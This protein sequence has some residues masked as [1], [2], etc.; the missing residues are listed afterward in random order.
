MSEQNR[1]R[2]FASAARIFHLWPLI[3]KT[4]IYS[5]YRRK[6]HP[7]TLLYLDVVITECCSLRCRDCA[8]L[9][10]YYRN[11]QNLDIE[12]VIRSL[13]RI[14]MSFRIGQLHIL[15]GEPFVS[16]KN[17]I[18]LLEF[19]NEESGDRVDKIIINTNGTIVPSEECLNIMKKTRNLELIFS[20]YGELSSKMGEFTQLCTKEEIEHH[21]LNEEVWWDFGD[22][23]PR[24]ENERSTQQRYDECFSRRHC[25]TLY[26]GKLYVCPRQ[27]HAT[28]LGIIPETDSENVDV[29]RT[30]Y[31]DPMV[32][33]D[34]V[35]A[36]LDR[37]KRIS[38]CKHCGCN[39]RKKIPRAVQ[40][41]RTI[42]VC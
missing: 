40:A 16:Q 3:T 41:E 7:G 32:L 9:M 42:D 39:S 14:L 36:L 12:E 28:H 24:E 37:K 21:S 11:P 18:R 5:H 6:K 20:N 17:L 22:L 13:G 19:I 26:R 8:N 38:T 10:Q 27:A 31:S 34:D 1:L 30:D 23:R 33:R 25:T 15:G 4:G 29:L 2:F 35:Y